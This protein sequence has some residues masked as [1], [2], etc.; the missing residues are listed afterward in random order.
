MWYSNVTNFWNLED[1]EKKIFS[2]GVGGIRNRDPQMI[3]SLMPAPIEYWPTTT[4]S[5]DCPAFDL[6]NINT[7]LLNINT[8][9]FLLNINIY[10][11]LLV[12]LSEWLHKYII[13]TQ[14]FSN[15]LREHVFCT[16]R[17]KWAKT[18]KSSLKKSNWKCWL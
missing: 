3:S 17:E 16:S 5:D 7:Y 1:F 8:Y 9:L 14:R 11:F 13:Q 10:S 15:P 6:L 4:F 2:E 18:D 12:S